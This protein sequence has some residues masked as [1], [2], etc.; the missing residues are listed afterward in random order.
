MN[1]L[2]HNVISAIVVVGNTHNVFILRKKYELDREYDF[3]AVYYD[4]KRLYREK[5]VK[6]RK[7]SEAKCQVSE[8]LIKNAYIYNLEF[9]HLKR[10]TR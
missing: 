8:Y 2:Y 3:R 5:I 7:V 10:R 9:L 6:N 4:M 1:F